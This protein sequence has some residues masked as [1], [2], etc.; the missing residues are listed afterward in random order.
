MDRT[1]LRSWT[2][3]AVAGE[4]IGTPAIPRVK[5]DVEEEDRW[6]KVRAPGPP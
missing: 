2:E 1:V 4:R 3:K 6:G 5:P